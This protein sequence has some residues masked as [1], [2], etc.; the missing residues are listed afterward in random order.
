MSQ[1][2]EVTLN[3]ITFRIPT[4]SQH[5]WADLTDWMLEV[6]EMLNTT[7]ENFRI[8]ASSANLVVNT[9]VSL[10]TINN[11]Q[12]NSHII[13][14]YG[15][16]RIT[17]GTGAQSLS[18]TGTFTMAYNEIAGTWETA[19][20]SVGDAEVVIDVSSNV[21]R[22]TAASITGDTIESNVIYFSGRIIRI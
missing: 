11:P 15:I 5:N 12:D 13:F 18:E 22:A 21:I 16:K 19:N 14:E 1:G 10:Y 9:P 3:G 4:S 7:S 2:I 6:N 8:P 20:V 17:S